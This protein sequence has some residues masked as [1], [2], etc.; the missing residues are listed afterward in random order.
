LLAE[1]HAVERQLRAVEVAAESAAGCRDLG[2][3]PAP[4]VGVLH[5]VDQ[6]PG[7]RRVEV[8]EKPLIGVDQVVRELA[9]RDLRIVRSEAPVEKRKVVRRPMAAALPLRQNLAD[10]RH[11]RGDRL[12]FPGLAV[13]ERFQ[14]LLRADKGIFLREDIE[15]RLEPL[16]HAIARCFLAHPDPEADALL[17][18][19]QVVKHIEFAGVRPVRQHLRDS[20]G[21]V[22]DVS[23]HSFRLQKLV[24]KADIRVHEDVQRRLEAE[25]VERRHA[26]AR[27]ILG[28]G[29]KTFEALRGKHR[30]ACNRRCPRGTYRRTRFASAQGSG[31]GSA[32]NADPRRY[33]P[34]HRARWRV[35]G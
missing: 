5:D 31:S 24:E 4:R 35:W 15:M 12:L 3:E 26:E 20:V 1:A 10:Q 25:H 6:C 11:D 32:R 9:Q 34:A 17:Q 23:A 7:Q 8:G 16:P 27:L 2:I 33:A 19:P 28:R 14:R 13:G 30:T 22:V 18:R 21:E 29:V